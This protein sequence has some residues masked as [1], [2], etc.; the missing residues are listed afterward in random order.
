MSRSMSDRRADPSPDRPPRP[1]RP[2][3]AELG[4][5]HAD[6]LPVIAVGG[7][8][9]SLARWGLAEAWPHR[10]GFP[11]ATFVT[12][13]SGA[14]LLGMLMALMLGPLSHTRYLRPF[15]GVGVLGGYTTFSTY[16]LETRGLLAAG[17]VGTAALYLFGSVALGLVAVFAGLSLGRLLIRANTYRNRLENR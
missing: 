5:A 11:F 7:A 16:Q 12:N 15:L 6:L 4:R 1:A 14:L 13:L 8:L 3:L 9:G 2:T 17:E 10:S